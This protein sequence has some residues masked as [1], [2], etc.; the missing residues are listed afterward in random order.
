[1]NLKEVDISKIQHIIVFITTAVKIELSPL[2]A[3]EV[4]APPMQEVAHIFSKSPTEH[5]VNAFGSPECNHLVS[6]YKIINLT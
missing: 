6:L 3:T 4:P 1:M 5:E 2:T